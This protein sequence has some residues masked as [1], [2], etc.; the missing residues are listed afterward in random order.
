MN[1][2]NAINGTTNNKRNKAKCH[3]QDKVSRVHCNTC[4]ECWNKS[5]ETLRKLVFPFFFF[6]TY[7]FIY[8][9]TRKLI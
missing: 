3:L 7:L 5:R 8:F 9:Y 2:F 1:E 4:N 6:I